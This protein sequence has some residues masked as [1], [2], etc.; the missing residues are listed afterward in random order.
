V[1]ATSTN[2]ALINDLDIVI[3][4]SG[5]SRT[6]SLTPVVDQTGLSEITVTV[7]DGQGSASQAFLFAVRPRPLP[8][9][10]LRVVQVFP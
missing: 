5:A 8:P 6:L 7:S 2:Q 3:S 1:S 4:G 10:G 9:G